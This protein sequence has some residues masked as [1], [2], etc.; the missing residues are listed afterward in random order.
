MKTCLIADDSKVV[1]TVAKQIVE[2]LGFSAAEAVDG[3]EAIDACGSAMPD[4]ILLDWNM[5][6]KNGLEFLTELRAMPSGNGPAVIFCTAE[7]DKEHVQQ[8]IEGG[9]DEYIMKPFDIND[10]EDKFTRLGLI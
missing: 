1:R 2:E 9:A 5:P 6:V 3:Q 7:H 8:A 4:V 10:V